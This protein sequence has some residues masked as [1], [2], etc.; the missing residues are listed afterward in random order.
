[1]PIDV[2]IEEDKVWEKSGK[3]QRKGEREVDIKAR[4]WFN[5]IILLPLSVFCNSLYFASEK[6]Q[7]QVFARQ[8]LIFNNRSPLK[9]RSVVS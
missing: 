9:R 3:R 8:T 6:I 4:K 1:M 5:D 7:S 2:W